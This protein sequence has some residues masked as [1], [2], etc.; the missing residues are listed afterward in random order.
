M[1]NILLLY[2]VAYFNFLFLVLEEEEDYPVG[3]LIC[4]VWCLGVQAYNVIVFLMLHLLFSFHVT[5]WWLV[6]KRIQF[7]LLKDLL[8]VSFNHILIVVNWFHYRM[9]SSR[10]QGGIQQLLAAEQEAQRIVNAA[11]N[12]I[13][14]ILYYFHLNFFLFICQS[15]LDSFIM[16]IHLKS[17]TM[18]FY[19]EFYS[20]LYCFCIG[21][22]TFTWKDEFLVEWV[23]LCLHP[24]PSFAVFSCYS[25]NLCEISLFVH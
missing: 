24:T 13:V 5:S 1:I 22:F 12:G 10:G 7:M 14:A 15:I 16:Y 6:C 23:C 11:K 18:P 17:L 19:L 21:L 2:V 9:A 3:Y 8:Y 25:Y 20:P 4:W